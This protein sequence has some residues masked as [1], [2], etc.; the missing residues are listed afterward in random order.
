MGR[1]FVTGFA[2]LIL[3]VAFW[4]VVGFL[5]ETPSSVVLVNWGIGFCCLFLLWGWFSGA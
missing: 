3:A 1:R 5:W 2:P 4:L